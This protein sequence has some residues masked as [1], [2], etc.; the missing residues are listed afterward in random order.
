[1]ASEKLIRELLQRYRNGDCSP[2][3]AAL[4]EVWFEQVQLDNTTESLLT[5][6]DEDRLVQQLKRNERFREPAPVVSLPAKKGLL[7]RFTRVAAAIWIGLL[8]VA[9][10]LAAYYIVINSSGQIEQ[11]LV[12]HEI[13][14]SPGERRKIV[15]PD[16]SVVWLN[17]RSTLGYHADFIHHRQI[18]L[19]GEAFFEVTHDSDHPFTVE[20]GDACAKVYGTAFNVY[21][22]EQ[23]RELR[24]A[25]QHGSIGVS[26][27]SS[28]AGREKRLSPGELLIYNTG[29]KEAAVITEDPQNIGAWT[30]GRLIF[31]QVPL[32]EVLAQLEREYQ[33]TYRYPSTLK[34]VLITAQFDHPSLEQVMKHISFGWNIRFSRTGNVINVQ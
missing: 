25:L 13:K 14:T 12:F 5:V 28:S 27:D 16:S 26:Y 4:L 32:E 15:L 19:N 8:L 3:E 10:G 7:K 9:G 6:E 34:D 24:I 22:Y 17:S 1:M 30:S 21:A 18:R 2:E 29:T 11:S 31:K 23:S 33:V 20:A